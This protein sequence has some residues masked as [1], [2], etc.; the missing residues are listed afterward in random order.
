[1]NGTI[2]DRVPERSWFWPD[3]DLEDLGLVAG[4]VLG[5]LLITLGLSAL[6]GG[7]HGYGGT[8]VAVMALIAVIGMMP[9]G[10]G[11]ILSMLH[12]KVGLPSAAVG[13]LLGLGIFVTFAGHCLNDTWTAPPDRPT[14]IRA[15]G[16]WT[17]GDLVVRAR[18]DRVVAYRGT[19]GEVAWSWTP[20][21]EDSVCAMSRE[22]GGGVGLIGHGAHDRPC[23]AVVAL[24]LATGAA[25]WTAPVDAPAR[26]G[27]GAAAGSLAIAGDRAVVQDGAGWRA[28]ALADGSTAWRS[29]PDTGC[30]PLHVAGGPGTV[31]T[32]AQCDHGSPVLRSLSPADGS[33]RLHAA[34]PLAN[35]LRTV[36]VLSTAPLTIW[37]DETGKRGTHAVLSFDPSGRIRS[38]IP[39]S[40]DAYDLDVLLGGASGPG[41]FTARPLYGAVIEDDLLIVPGEKP[42]D[43][44]IGGKNHNSRSATGRLVAYSLADG[45]E[46]WTSGLDDQVTGLTVDGTGVWAMT[47]STVTRVDAATGH[48]DAQFPI[49]D[50]ES[51]YPADL[52]V[53]GP[54]R[55]TVLAE[56]G[57]AAEPP[58]RGLR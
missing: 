57:T 35:G 6:F 55:F 22:T 40:G 23:A 19:T 37:A 4:G 53:V 39:V 10:A 36:A 34:L 54:N 58:A 27:D 43:V 51:D 56:D 32:V 41:R 49:H 33:E 31:V 8:S 42:G 20:P 24:D 28:L 16:T 7:D 9:C 18:P 44:T 29:A 46:R 1:M 2:S 15:V 3:V 45:G 26:T 50:T 14:G 12:P 13:V 11:F 38:T 17:S 47:R 25:R 48:Q 5:A 30:A 52:S 21:A